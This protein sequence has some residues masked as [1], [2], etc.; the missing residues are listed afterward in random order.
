MS[1]GTTAV[2]VRPTTAADVARAGG[3]AGV[4]RDAGVGGDPGADGAAGADGGTSSFPD[5]IED[6]WRPGGNRRSFVAV[7]PDS[8]GER[9]VGH[10][11]AVD[12]TVHPNSRVML[13]EVAPDVQGQGVDDAL[14][15]AQ[16]EASS[17][18]PRM[19]IYEHQVSDQQLAARFGGIAVQVTPP[20]RYVVGPEMRA[21]ATQHAPDRTVSISPPRPADSA[22]LLALE[23]DHYIDQHV[24]WSPT[25]PREVMLAELG[26]DHDPQTP[27]T[28]DRGRSRVL[29]RDGR[30]AAAVLV[31]PADDASDA[32][33]GNQDGS[34]GEGGDASGA[35]S[36]SGAPEISLLSRPYAGPTSRADKEAC[37]AALIEASADGDQLLIDSHL[38]MRE[39]WAMMREVPGLVPSDGTGWMTIT[40][41]PVPGGPA[42]VPVPH[43]LV[44]AETPWVH[45]L[46]P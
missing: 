11:R 14:L 27:G 7:V 40:A 29:Q 37:L 25:A 5:L 32:D 8:A 24:S 33:A 13:L 41:I 44:P 31:W 6:R 30:I 39:E 22:D 16:V 23:V 28:W 1:G 20:W 36:A 43:G 21:W 26:E 4:G 9:I 10:C 45:T 17:V 18:P 35:A 15:H 12:N 46:L 3:T 38:T 19:K 42:P 2:R 34:E